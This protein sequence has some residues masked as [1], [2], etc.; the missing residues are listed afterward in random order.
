M[1]GAL[2]R[3]D[4][5]GAQ[6]QALEINNIR[7]RGGVDI[8]S[9]VKWLLARSSDGIGERRIWRRMPLGIQPISSSL[10]R[11]RVG[12]KHRAWHFCAEAHR[13]SRWP[14]IIRARILVY[15]WR[16]GDGGGAHG[17]R[18]SGETA[19]RAPGSS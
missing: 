18:K 6:W 19:C 14:S 10:R 5:D 16:I 8:I 2:T 7:A 12:R 4:T 15:P 3:A 17:V 11:R 9:A 13:C 1:V